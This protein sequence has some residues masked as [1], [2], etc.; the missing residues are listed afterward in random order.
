MSP[1]RQH[2][3]LS[4]ADAFQLYDDNDLLRLRKLH[5]VDP[6]SAP[7][8]CQA[9]APVRRAVARAEAQLRAQQLPQVAS[10][11]ADSVRQCPLPRRCRRRHH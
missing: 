11:V 4:F 7:A 1:D 2:A 10:S 5:Q 6:V 8:V 3:V 9:D